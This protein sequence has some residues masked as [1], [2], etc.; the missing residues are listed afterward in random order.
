[1]SD[2]DDVHAAATA[3]AVALAS[4]DEAALRR[5][6]HPLFGWV[7]HRGDVFDLAGYLAANVD[8]GRWESQRLDDVD[9]VVTGRTAVLR[10]VAVDIVDGA[11][12]RMPMTQVWVRADGWRCLA[13]HAGPLLD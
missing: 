13:G 12:F 7:S 3:R 8:T 10:C 1:V 6:L 4:G 2:A 9:V 5:L 11:E